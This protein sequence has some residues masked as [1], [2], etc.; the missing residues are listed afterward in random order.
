M[1]ASNQT[2]YAGLTAAGVQLVKSLNLFGSLAGP[3]AGQI[4]G[5]AGSASLPPDIVWDYL[6][7][8]M[9]ICTKTGDINTVTWSQMQ[10]IQGG[11]FTNLTISG[12]F[13]SQTG[14]VVAELDV[15]NLV[16]GG[17][18]TGNISA[19]GTLSLTNAGVTHNVAGALQVGGALT[20]TGLA[21]FHGNI[22]NTGGTYTGLSI[23]LTGGMIANNWQFVANNQ[24][25]QGKTTGGA[26]QIMS[27]IDS[28]NHHTHLVSGG[29]GTFWRI[30]NQAF[31][32]SLFAVDNVG[33]IYL[34]QSLVA[35]PVASGV[36]GAAYSA[37]QFIQANLGGSK[38]NFL[39]G[40]SGTGSNFMAF[41]NGTSTVIGSISQASGTTTAFNTTSD[42]RLKLDD[43]LIDPRAATKLLRKLRPHWFRWKDNPEGESEPGFFAQEVNRLWRWA[44]TK[45]RTLEKI[46]HPWQM[47]NAK[48][49]PLVVAALQDAHAR[50]D[51]LE[52][53]R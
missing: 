11:Q 42:R 13:T 16:V 41:F 7:A 21:A 38:N 10:F 6:N 45:A 53:A 47:D 37:N 4:G 28:A 52:K 2:P 32:L 49:L 17:S 34:N 31:T 39:V 19:I 12:G 9:W 23:T 44:V 36:S 5:Q 8:A 25:F 29:A 30:C 1:S 27:G 14:A 40:V 48:L 24:F 51:Q 20:V 26:L 35:N 46:Y 50:I 18:G 3:P 43:G 33:N 22:Q 15:G